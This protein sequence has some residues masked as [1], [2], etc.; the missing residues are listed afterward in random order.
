MDVK[1]IKKRLK[2]DPYFL[3]NTIVHNNP[4]DV[5]LKLNRYFDVQEANETAL[6]NTLTEMYQNGQQGIVIDVLSVP[7]DFE[8]ATPELIQAKTEL[9][10]ELNS[11]AKVSAEQ[12]GQWAT[13]AGGL[14]GA[15]G[16]I[17]GP[18][19]QNNTST[20]P[21]QPAEPE[22]KDKTWMYV[23]GAVLLLV[24]GVLIFKFRK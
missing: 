4:V 20:Q 18:K 15:L 24:I 11:G 13:V 5:A 1:E 12:A 10:A 16:G 7:F 8:N 3:I 19:P 23:G 6:A 21:Q 14:L 2:S 9:T 17:L 22:K